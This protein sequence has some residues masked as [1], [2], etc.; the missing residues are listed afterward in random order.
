[1]LSGR[2][3]PGRDVAIIGMGGIGFDVALYLLERA[4]R[5]PLDAG[6][7]CGALGNP[8]GRRP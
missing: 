8:S 2:V 4:S 7:L 6:R 1:M 5:A 3:E